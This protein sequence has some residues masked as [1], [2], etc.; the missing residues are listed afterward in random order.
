[1]S[2]AIFLECGNVEWSRAIALESTFCVAIEVAI[3]GCRSGDE[4]YSHR[5]RERRLRDPQARFV[6]HADE[7]FS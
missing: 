7:V 2:C 1:M 6:D 4:D 5:L 3:V